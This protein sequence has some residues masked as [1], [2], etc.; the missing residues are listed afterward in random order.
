MTKF[1]RSKSSTIIDGNQR[2]VMS[3]TQIPKQQKETLSSS[4]NSTPEFASDQQSTKMIF[5]MIEMLVQESSA[6]KYLC[7]TL[8]LK[9]R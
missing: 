8:D 6:F 4:I 2:S 9:S 7:T 1:R 5:S 3:T